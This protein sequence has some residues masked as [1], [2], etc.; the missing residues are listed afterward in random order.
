MEITTWAGVLAGM[1]AGFTTSIIWVEQFKADTH[2]LYEAIPGFI[3]GFVVTLVV[4][5][6]GVEAIILD[7][8]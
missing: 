4:T 1:I 6:D 7:C 3:A 2:D 8:T 5:C